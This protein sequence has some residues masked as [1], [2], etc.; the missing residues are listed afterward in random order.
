MSVSTTN[1]SEKLVREYFMNAEKGEEDTVKNTAMVAPGL[2]VC[3]MAANNVSGG[4]R[5]GPLFGGMLLSGKI[6]AHGA[7]TQ[8]LEVSWLPSVA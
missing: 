6:L 3:G 2:F 4:S 7:M 5:M 1:P 8:G